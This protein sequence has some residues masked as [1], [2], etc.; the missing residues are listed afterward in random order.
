MEEFD[1]EIFDEELFDESDTTNYENEDFTNELEENRAP[2]VDFPEANEDPNEK[3]YFEL[4]DSVQLE[5]QQA[6]LSELLDDLFIK[7]ITF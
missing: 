2:I 4:R 1:D 5:L 3:N 6:L 7:I